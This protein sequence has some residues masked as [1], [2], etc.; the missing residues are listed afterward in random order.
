M[1]YAIT[2]GFIALDII[3]GNLKALKK[4]T[5]CSSIMREG[6]FHKMAFVLFIALAVLCDFGQKY[7]DIGFTIPISKGVCVYVITCEIGSVWENLYII[8]PEITAKA[9]SFFIH[10]KED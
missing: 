7:L 5:W 3:S 10:S 4:R 1:M 2:A 9:K 8:N 6:L